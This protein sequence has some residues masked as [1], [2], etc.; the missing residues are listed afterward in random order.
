MTK[1]T[2]V[3]D[4]STEDFLL[5]YDELVYTRA[6]MLREILIKYLPGITEQ[7]DLP[8]KMIAYCYGQK[9]IDLI[10]VIIP[11]QKGL[12]LG[13]NRGVEL[14]DPDGL[15]DGAGKIS[16]YVQIISDEQITSEAL[17]KLLTSALHLYKLK[18]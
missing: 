10:C 9:Y 5:Q 8:A 2:V 4:K 6:F 1:N 18:K 7:M 16:R 15:L 14:D 11:S 3:L 12:K 13:F 17:K